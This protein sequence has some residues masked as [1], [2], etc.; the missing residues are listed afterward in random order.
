[1]WTD[2]T[3]PAPVAE[4][5][6]GIDND[7]VRGADDP[8]VFLLNQP[9]TVGVGSCARTGV[10]RCTPGGRGVACDA[11]PGMSATEECN[12]ADDDCDGEV[13]EL[14]DIAPLA[15]G[16]DAPPCR[17]RVDVC[18]DGDYVTI[19]TAHAPG[20]ETCNGVDDDCDGVVDQPWRTG[21]MAL[22]MP[23]AR[24]WDACRG[25]TTG[26]Y[27]CAP[28]GTGTICNAPEPAG[29]PAQPESCN[30]VDDDCDGEIDGTRGTGGARIPLTRPCYPFAD[31]STR[32]VGSCRTGTTTCDRGRFGDCMGAIGPTAEVCDQRNNDCDAQTD[33]LSV[34]GAAFD[35]GT[36]TW[37]FDD[38]FERTD[39]APWSTANSVRAVP[40]LASGLTSTGT[41]AV[42]LAASHLGGRDQRAAIAYPIHGCASFV[43]LQFD[44]AVEAWTESRA[45]IALQLVG[46]PGVIALSGS[47]SGTYT[48]PSG[49]TSF[50]HNLSAR[51]AWVSFRLVYDR[52]D[53]RLFESGG[54]VF[55]VSNVATISGVELAATT[56][57][58]DDAVAQ[59]RVDR[60][61]L[62]VRP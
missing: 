55:R 9:C 52:G 35:A 49:T 21:A 48:P 57:C 19:Q 2:C 38:D 8:W 51:N 27:V 56:C 46:L 58:A 12:G 24:V 50:V 28:D 37:T 6:D 41:R 15:I 43:E 7:G 22:G 33:E 44:L 25:R 1:M 14:S 23:C 61:R 40:F 36:S 31:A 13:D 62:R 16:F 29:R 17:P 30:D 18:I 32:N 20:T 4:S 45:E 26:V 53:V 10:Y 42:V 11:V 5:C 34:D 59:I 3:A 60:V 54:E 39:I 47:T